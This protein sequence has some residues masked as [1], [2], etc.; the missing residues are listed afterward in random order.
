MFPERSARM[1]RLRFAS[2][3]TDLIAG[4]GMVHRATLRPRIPGLLGRRP[5]L[6]R[7]LSAVHSGP[8]SVEA[9]CYSPDILTTVALA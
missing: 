7:A 5:G 2:A 3:L 1:A 6:A 9:E 8:W 4:F